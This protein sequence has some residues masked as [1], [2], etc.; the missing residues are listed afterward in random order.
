MSAVTG[1]TLSIVGVA[2]LGGA[3]ILYALH[4]DEPEPLTAPATDDRSVVGQRERTEN[5]SVRAGHLN[6]D[7][8]DQPLRAVLQQIADQTGMTLFVSDEVGDALVSLRA[9]NLALETG[10]KALLV[11]TDSFLLYGRTKA[12]SQGIVGL[13]VYARGRGPNFAPMPVDHSSDPA[14]I[15]GVPADAAPEERARSVEALVQHRGSASVPAVLQALEDEDALVRSRALDAAV[16]FGLKVPEDVLIHRIRVDQSP[17]VRF[18]ALAGLATLLDP[19]ITGEA[20]VVNNADV[21]AISEL[22]LNDPNSEVR[23][24]AQQN[25][26]ALNALDGVLPPPEP[27]QSQGAEQER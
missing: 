24:Q 22:A 16:N 12:S 15:N 6:I 26:Q 1:R 3:W 18:I 23:W 10:L 5:V 11:N 25:L 19:H 17:E 13:W 9:E 7:V 14:E 20:R 8:I 21:R 4:S 27:E 2:L